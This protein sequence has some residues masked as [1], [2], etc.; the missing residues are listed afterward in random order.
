[1]LNENRPSIKREVILPVCSETLLTDSVSAIPLSIFQADDRNLLPV[2][3]CNY[4]NIQ[5]GK[6]AQM[7]YNHVEW[8][9]FTVE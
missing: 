9:D 4:T 5:K 1:M 3:L 6:Y 7:E 8:T 2:I